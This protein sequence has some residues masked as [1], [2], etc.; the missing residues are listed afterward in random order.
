MNPEA[1][2]TLGGL[3]CIVFAVFHLFFWKLFRWNTE[4]A[5][6]TSLNRA[7]M[8]ILNLCLT[9]VFVMVAYISLVHARELLTTALG[10]ALLLLIAAFWYLRAIEQIWFFGLKKPLSLL[11]FLIF[12]MGGLLYTA[13]VL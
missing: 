1:L 13:P 11:F 8:Q 10:Q 5:K 9:F 12:V 3:L 7:V 2:L 6:L 4:L